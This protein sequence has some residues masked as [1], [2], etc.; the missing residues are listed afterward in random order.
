MIQEERG[1]LRPSEAVMHPND[2]NCDS[3][4]WAHNLKEEKKLDGLT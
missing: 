3:C 1:D 2:C 4:A